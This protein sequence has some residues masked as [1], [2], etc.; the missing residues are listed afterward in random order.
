MFEKIKEI[1]AAIDVLRID[2]FE[3]L[4]AYIREDALHRAVSDFTIELGINEN[5]IKALFGRGHAYLC[6]GDYEKAA[7]DFFAALHLAPRDINIWLSLGHTHICNEEYASAIVDFSSAFEL[8]NDLSYATFIA[9]NGY[10]YYLKID[11]NAAIAI[12]YA[13]LN[14]EPNNISFLLRRAEAY[15]RK[16]LFYSAIE[17]CTSVLKINK[18]NINAL[19]IRVL[20]YADEN[21][22]DNV[23]SDCTSLLEFDKNNVD[24]LNLRAEAYSMKGNHDKAA[25][26]FAL[27][28]KIEENS[29]EVLLSRILENISNGEYN[30]AIKALTT[31]HEADEYNIDV[32]LYRGYCYGHI[33]DFDNAIA[34]F[35]AAHE[36]D[37]Y[38]IDALLWCGKA[39][40]AVGNYA[41]AIKHLT[42][43]LEIEANTEV[44]FYRAN[45]YHGKR[46]YNHAIADF[47]KLIEVNP[48]EA[49]ALL[50][51]GCTY[52]ANGEYDKGMEDIEKVSQ[53][54]IDNAEFKSVLENILNTINSD[55]LPPAIINQIATA[56]ENKPE[57]LEEVSKIAFRNLTQKDE[58]NIKKITDAMNTEF[59]SNWKEDNVKRG[60]AIYL[61]RQKKVPLKNI[62]PFFSFSNASM[63]SKIDTYMKDIVKNGEEARVYAGV[64]F[65]K[66][67][68]GEKNAKLWID[69]IQKMI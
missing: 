34:D 13:V 29:S 35:T 52:I 28:R 61:M 18:N 27:K 30:I 32:L 41:I 69:K 2:G 14:I 42:N 45:A 40:V 19:Y 1:Q 43:I 49:K 53:M 25:E 24:V 8:F 44:L 37:E 33:G 23:I 59:E 48:N 62:A 50:G 68:N 46:D 3:C 60:V 15:S 22:Y 31:M 64:D 47:N 36:I 9:H 54:N 12:C 26:D 55:S 16:G 38:D 51:R 56:L 65:K 17:D 21:D 39:N 58:Q 66:I 5:T 57:F 6:E 20:A 11:L 7:E 67:P 63:V 10:A 4:Q